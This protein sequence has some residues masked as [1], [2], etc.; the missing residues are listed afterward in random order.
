MIFRGSGPVL[1]RNPIFLWFFRG[2]GLDPF[3]PS[4]SAHEINETHFQGKL[5]LHTCILHHR[6]SL[7]ECFFFFWGGGGGR[8]RKL[9]EER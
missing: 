9:I 8:S 1:L 3:S 7:E 5:N 2:G 6:P 4:G